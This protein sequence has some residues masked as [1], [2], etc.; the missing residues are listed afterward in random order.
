[1]KAFSKKGVLTKNSPLEVAEESDAVITMLPSS[2]HVSL[3]NHIAV[4]IHHSV[5]A[6]DLA[7]LN[8]MFVGNK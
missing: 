2:A 8:L 3:I 1:M 4:T 5:F 7:E 6:S